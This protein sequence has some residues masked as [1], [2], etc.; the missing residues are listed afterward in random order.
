MNVLSHPS[1]K[2]NKIKLVL[3]WLSA[4]YYSIK[5]G[6]Q[7][8][9]LEQLTKLDNNIKVY[10]PSTTDVDK[11]VDTS[12]QIDNTLTLLSSKFG[13]STST[14]G[15]GTWV[16]ETSGLVKEEV[17]ICESYCTGSALKNSL[18]EVIEYCE[19]LKKELSQ[20]AISLEVNNKLYFI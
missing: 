14:K 13:G 10:V 2:K 17:T 1:I 9:Q 20:E 11:K 12:K 15:T 16:S 4:V 7:M 3:Y 18:T 6:E 8:K 5:Q 19:D